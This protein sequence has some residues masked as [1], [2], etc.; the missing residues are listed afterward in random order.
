MGFR[1]SSY[2]KA[3]DSIFEVQGAAEFSR[4]SLF[5]AWLLTHCHP[6]QG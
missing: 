3:A 6:T 2:L 1:I 5:D 4:K